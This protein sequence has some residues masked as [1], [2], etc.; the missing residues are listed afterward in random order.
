MLLYIDHL[1]LTN[2]RI[3]HALLRHDCNEV[4][5]NVLSIVDGDNRKAD[6]LASWFGKVAKSCDSDFRIN[7]DIAMMRMWQIG[8]VN[9]KGID[10]FGHP[11]FSLTYSGAEI[12]RCVSKEDLFEALLFDNSSTN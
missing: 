2:Q 3:R 10:D 5:E 9:L 6:Y 12:V 8:N 7:S 11:I 4:A 1:S